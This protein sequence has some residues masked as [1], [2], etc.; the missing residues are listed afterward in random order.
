MLEL[1]V[2][3]SAV[4]A[5]ILLV[6]GVSILSHI[7]RTLED[8]SVTLGAIR[9]DSR[10]TMNYGRRILDVLDRIELAVRH[11]RKP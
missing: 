5:A 2:A 8:M 10:E 4:V 3:A 6:L 11:P 1:A 9:R 7:A